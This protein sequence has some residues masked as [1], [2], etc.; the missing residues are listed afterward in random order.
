[1][2]EEGRISSVT[3]DV[4]NYPCHWHADI[5]C[6]SGQMCD[7]CEHQPA[8]EEKKNG[9]APPLPLDW[10]P[11][12]D[13]RGMGWPVCPACGEMPYSTIRCLFCGQQ[14]IQDRRVQKYN[15]P[16][17]E[18]RMDCPYCGGEKTLVGYRARSNG[19]FHGV[20]EACGVH[21]IE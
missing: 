14:F 6:S 9:T 1:M 11:A 20:C 8:P 17:E 19:H 2:E 21:T 5:V 4:T 10:E 7:G 3:F 18:V 13:G 16:P 12:C 15:E